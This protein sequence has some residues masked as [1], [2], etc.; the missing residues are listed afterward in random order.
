MNDID[1]EIRIASATEGVIDGQRVAL[2]VDAARSWSTFRLLYE[3]TRERWADIVPAVDDEKVCFVI[4]TFLLECIRLNPQDADVRIRT[5]CEAC[6]ACC[7]MRRTATRS[8]G[9][10]QYPYLRLSRWPRPCHCST[11]GPWDYQF[12]MCGRLQRLRPGDDQ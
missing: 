4:R 8:D 7:A 10:A 1:Q 5:T 12:V 6:S 2:W 9:G 3:L 11:D